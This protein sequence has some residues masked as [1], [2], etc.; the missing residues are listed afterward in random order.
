MYKYQNMHLS[1]KCPKI[2][3]KTWK[4]NKYDLEEQYVFLDLLSHLPKQPNQVI[5]ALPQEQ[6]ADLKNL[7]S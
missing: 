5:G 2:K 1:L 4:K 6:D 3:Y 7:N